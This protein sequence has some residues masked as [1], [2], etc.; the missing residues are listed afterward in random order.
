MPSTRTWPVASR[1]L[2]RA[3][4]DQGDQA[5]AETCCKRAVGIY[6]QIGGDP[7]EFAT[8]LEDYASFLSQGGPR[9]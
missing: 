6:E 7:A 4:L 3:Y 2:A 5:E 8:A 9:C 1:K